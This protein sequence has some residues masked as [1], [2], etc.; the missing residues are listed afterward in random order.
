MR[1]AAVGNGCS[2]DCGFERLED[3]R[4]LSSEPL[5]SAMIIDD[6]EPDFA[7]TGAWTSAASAN[8]WYGKDVTYARAGGG[9][10]QAEWTFP[11]LKQDSI[12]SRRVGLRTSQGGQRMRPIRSGSTISASPACTSISGQL[13]PT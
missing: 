10:A 4:L 5:D 11:R 8:S 1:A 6:G 9:E 3:R 12:A 13:R 2:A 7:A